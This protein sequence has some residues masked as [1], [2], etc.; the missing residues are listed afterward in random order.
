[1]LREVFLVY[2]SGKPQLKVPEFYKLSLRGCR[3]SG[4]TST[5]VVLSVRR[6]GSSPSCT[7]RPVICPPVATI[8]PH[9][10]VRL[11]ILIVFL[12]S[13]IRVSV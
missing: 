4:P 7:N 8:V 9:R 1:M 11:R 2:N 13:H 12:Y 6:L 5:I 3:E 10:F